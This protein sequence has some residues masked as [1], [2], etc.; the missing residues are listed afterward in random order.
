M[1]WTTPATWTIGQLVSAAAL[2]EQLRDNL[3][4]LKLLVDATGK[5]PAL[6]STYL[7]SLSG[8]S[9][10]GIMKTALDNDFTVGVQDFSAGATTRVVLPTGSDKWAT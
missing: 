8:A 5:I 6:S 9:L 2:N 4:F 1:A 3:I 10:T 7:A